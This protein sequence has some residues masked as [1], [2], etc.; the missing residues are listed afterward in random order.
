[1]KPEIKSYYAHHFGVFDP[2]TL[3]DIYEIGEYELK[4]INLPEVSYK[5]VKS[6]SGNTDAAKHDEMKEILQ[7]V[8]SLTTN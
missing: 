2:L 7:T 1:M 6:D 8:L 4:I 5:N 3:N